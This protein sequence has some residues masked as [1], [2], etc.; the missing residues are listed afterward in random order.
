LVQGVLLYAEKLELTVEDPEPMVLRKFMRRLKFYRL[1]AEVERASATAVKLTLS[2]PASLFGENRKYGLQL[3]AFFQVILLLKNW[4]LKADVKIHGE[5]T[6]TLTLSCKKCDLKSPI[7]RW[8]ECLPD[9]VA[10]F[11]RAFRNEPGA[12][13]EAPD[14]PLPRIAT[15]GAFFPDFSFERID[16]PGRVVHVELFHRYYRE[17]LEKRLDFLLQMP[18]FPLVV[19]VDRAALGK[20]G[21]R[22]LAEKYADLAD[23]LFFFSN[24]PGVDRVRK[25]LE[26]TYQSSV[27]LI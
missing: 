4:S 21:E 19:G 12:W 14:A 22:Q 5:R 24:Y 2:G 15:Q 9:E 25:M 1:L 18:D 11:I 23:K 6:D 8:T 16:E 20:D 7:R 10:M 13:R 3:A 26:K 17:S 27:R